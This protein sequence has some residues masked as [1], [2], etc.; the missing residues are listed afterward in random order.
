MGT[1]YRRTPKDYDGTKTTMR[2]MR[3]MLP[4]VLGGVQKVYH[5][6][7][8]L[9]LAAW[10]EIIGAQL[11]QMTQALSFNNGVLIVKV[12]NSTL[13]S[14]L[15]QQHDKSRIIVKLRQRFPQIEIKTVVFRMG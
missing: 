12:R 8:D 9:I 7:S 11:A 5:D 13:H 15:S 14:L 6:R 4:A 10:P 3:E 1:T 2:Q